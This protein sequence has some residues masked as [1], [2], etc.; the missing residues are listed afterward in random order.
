MPFLKRFL[1]TLL[2]TL[3]RAVLAKYHPDVVG[4][5]GSVGKTSAT[6]AITTVLSATYEVGKPPKNYNNE[7][8]LPLAVLGLASGGRSPLAW[9]RVIA[10]GVGLLVRRVPYPKILV[11]ELGADHPGAI[12]DR[13]ALV[14][15]RGGAGTPVGPARPG[16]QRR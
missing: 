13:V 3:A 4:V 5:T 2:R 15:P 7:I 6:G 1:V 8:G 16:A 9:L 12:A 11:L 10:H 14:R